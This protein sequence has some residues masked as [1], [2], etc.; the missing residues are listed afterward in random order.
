MPQPQWRLTLSQALSKTKE[1]F[2]NHATIAETLRKKSGRYHLHQF[3]PKFAKFRSSVCANRRGLESLN[4]CLIA[5]DYY[6]LHPIRFSDFQALCQSNQDVANVASCTKI[7]PVGIC[8]ASYP[9]CWWGASKYASKTA[10]ILLGQSTQTGPCPKEGSCRRN[11]WVSCIRSRVGTSRGEA[12]R[13]KDD[14]EEMER[15]L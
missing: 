14:M 11:C 13:L 1:F 8:Q 15:Y 12:T 4:S 5:Q 3:Y 10:R 7:W 6:Y 9:C 2:N